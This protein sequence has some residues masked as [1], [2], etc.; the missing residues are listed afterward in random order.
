MNETRLGRPMLSQG[1]KDAWAGAEAQ[2]ESGEFEAALDTMRDAWTEH[3]D[4]ADH[5][6]TWKLVGDAKAGQAREGE[7]VKRKL[8]RAAH[9]EYQKALKKDP[10]HRAARRAD[11]ALLA[12]LDGMGVRA[13]NLPVMFD[14]GAP[15]IYGL[16]AIIVSV[17]LLLTSLKYLPDIKDALGLTEAWDESYT[18]T[19]TFELYADDAPNT[20][21]SFK[22]HAIEGNY[23]DVIFHR[24][25]DGFMI[26][27]GDIES[28]NGQGGYAAKWFGQGDQS[29]PTSYIVPDEFSPNRRHD[30]GA[31]AMA[32]SGANSAGSQF[33]IVDKEATNSQDGEPGTH[34][35]DGYD[36][37]DQLKSCGT[38]GVSCH[39]VFGR[40]IGG[41]YEGDDIGGL[42]M[43]DIISQ[44]ETNDQ[45]LPLHPPY[46]H[47]IDIDGNTAYMHIVIP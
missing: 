43:V 30:V 33:Y 45:S 9:S 3:G 5:A 4:T 27:G 42:D 29:D 36:E 31:L 23:D 37:N 39:T 7:T 35:L 1:L 2:I 11:S 46:I 21:E 25:I 19:L 15:T 17:L 26:Q 14:D 28:G 24:I 38:Q 41:T 12:E 32:N 16:M 20:V 6:N 18:A 13:T 22:I 10:K 44:V 8:L 34:W 40:V 47:S